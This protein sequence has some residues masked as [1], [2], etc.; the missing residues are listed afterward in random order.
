M[1]K[2][3]RELDCDNVHN[4]NRYNKDSKN[5]IYAGDVVFYPYLKLYDNTTKQAEII[6]NVSYNKSGYPVFLIFKDG[7]W[8]RKSAKYF[9]PIR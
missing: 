6:Y 7:Q 4:P 9:S 3:K 1:T 5:G 8:I 2:F